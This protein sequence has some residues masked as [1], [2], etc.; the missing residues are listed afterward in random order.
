MDKGEKVLF[1]LFVLFIVLTVVV[2]DYH[3]SHSYLTV[4]V[5]A[6]ESSFAPSSDEFL[7][8][9]VPIEGGPTMSYRFNGSITLNISKATLPAF[10]NVWYYENKSWRW[11]AMGLTIQEDGKITGIESIGKNPSGKVNPYTFKV[12][13][14]GFK[15]ERG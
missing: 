5:S 11:L 9:I 14:L 6:Y 1:V 12:V 3:T 10:L 13:V 8:Q 15:S 7:V 2:E 4:V